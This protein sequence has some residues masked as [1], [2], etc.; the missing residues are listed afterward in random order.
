[1]KRRC[2]PDNVVALPFTRL[3]HRVHERRVLLVDARCLTIHVRLVVVRIEDL[4]L[5]ACVAG[6][7]RG[8]KDAAVA[9]GLT[10]SRD[11]LRDA[12][13]EVELIVGEATLRLDVAG[14]LVHRDHAVGNGPMRGRVIVDRYPLVE[15]VTV[16]QHDRIGRRRSV[17]AAGCDNTGNGSPDLG[18][19]WP[20][21]RPLSKKG[22]AG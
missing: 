15:I 6:T 19:L 17:G 4:D 5:V 10:R 22:Y 16:E 3:S 13:L 21:L 11:A 1:M 8:E 7:G 9:A 2:R 20:G 18:V 12:P 14:G